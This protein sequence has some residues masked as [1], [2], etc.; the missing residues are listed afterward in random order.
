[1]KSIL[2]KLPNWIGDILFSY[3]LL[4]SLS[5]NVDRLV[6]LTSQEHSELFQIFPIS[7][8]SP[9]ECVM[10]IWQVSAPGQRVATAADQRAR[11]A[12]TTQRH[13]G[14]SRLGP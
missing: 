8:A 9:L 10:A 4:F 5:Q 3:D 6:L 2:V 13:R 7:N 11:G 12:R 1:M 14:R